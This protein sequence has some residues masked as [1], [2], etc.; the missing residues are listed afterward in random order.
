[1][2]IEYSA[3]GIHIIKILNRGLDNDNLLTLITL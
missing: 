3:I 2:N 1:M